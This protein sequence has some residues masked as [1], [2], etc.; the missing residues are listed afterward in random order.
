VSSKNGKGG[1]PD[2]SPLSVVHGAFQVGNI[3]FHGAQAASE[4]P[5]RRTER[6]A[7]WAGVAA[8]GAL[9]WG[10]AEAIFRG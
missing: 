4:P 5:H 1:R 3:L 9:L 6:F 8:L 7:K 2:V 10:I